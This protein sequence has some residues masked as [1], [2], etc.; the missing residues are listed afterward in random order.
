MGQGI[1]VV[2]AVVGNG[3]LQVLIRKLFLQVIAE[4]LGRLTQGVFVY[5]VISGPHDTSHAARTKFQGL[6]ETIF[7]SFGIVSDHLFDLLLDV[8]VKKGCE[9][10][11]YSFEQGGID[12]SHL[13]RNFGQ[14]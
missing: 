8:V 12:I 6:V 11:V 14:R 10:D 13:P 7:Q 2:A 3:H 1:A 9:P 4:P 5:A